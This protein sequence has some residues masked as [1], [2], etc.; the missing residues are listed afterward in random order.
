MADYLH[1]RSLEI[2]TRRLLGNIEC[3]GADS[4]GQQR[5]LEHTRHCYLRP[6]T[7]TKVEAKAG[8]R[9]THLSHYHDL[10]I[11]TSPTISAAVNTSRHLLC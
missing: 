1:D 2:N 6:Y 8:A 4:N 7:S 11:N 9:L 5:V 10:Q 3:P